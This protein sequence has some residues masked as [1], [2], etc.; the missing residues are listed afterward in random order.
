MRCIGTFMWDNPF[1]PSYTNK[2]PHYQQIPLINTAFDLS[3]HIF[4]LRDFTPLN[5]H[6]ISLCQDNALRLISAFYYRLFT[7]TYSKQVEVS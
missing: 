6:S 7:Y 2:N 4:D 1:T 5:V 3:Y